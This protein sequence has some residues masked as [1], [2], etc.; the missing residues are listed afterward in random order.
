MTTA[1]YEYTQTCPLCHREVECDHAS[2]YEH[3]DAYHPEIVAQRRPDTSS[4]QRWAAMK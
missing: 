3:M 4:L 1:L 2:E